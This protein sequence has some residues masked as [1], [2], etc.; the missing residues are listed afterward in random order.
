MISVFE[1]LFSRKD[2]IL[3]S[4]QFPYPT[5]LQFVKWTQAINAFSINTKIMCAKSVKIKA[6]SVCTKIVIMFEIHFVID[7]KTIILESY[8]K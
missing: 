8:V 5:S 7:V 6:N 1:F 3:C 4:Y 2:C